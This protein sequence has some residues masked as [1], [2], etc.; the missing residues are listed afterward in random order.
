[1]N[2]LLTDHKRPPIQG[3]LGNLDLL[4]GS[5]IIDFGTNT[6]YMR[7]VKKAVWPQLEGKWVGVRYEQDGRK[8]PYKAGDAAVGFKNGRIRF[9]TPGKTAEWGFHLEDEL[10]LYRVGLFDAGADELADGFRYSGG[11]LLL[12]VKGDTLSIVMGESNEFAAPKG[13][14]L[15]LVEYVRAK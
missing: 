8:G 3:L 4:N 2:K 9:T 11:G 10:D 7:P 15:L 6:I 12:R 13:S 5:A 1:L 14:G